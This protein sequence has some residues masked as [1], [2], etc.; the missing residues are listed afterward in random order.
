[1]P[2]PPF[3][4]IPRA[5]PRYVAFLRGVSPTNAKMPELKRCFESAGFADVK[6]LLSSGNVVFTSPKAAER[7]LVRKA[8]QAMQDGLGGAFGTFIRPADALQVLIDSDPYAA[9]DLPQGAKR[10]ITFLRTEVTP[11]IQLPFQQDDT[12]IW[13]VRGTEVLS[14]YVPGPHGPLFMRLLE[15]TFG[16]DVTTRSWDTVRK[17]AL[18]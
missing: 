1:M 12:C 13:Q 4:I 11:A 10:V 14:S 8:Q 7:A 17:C 16:S 2:F 9:W 18:A 15:R 6:T 3:S 5:M